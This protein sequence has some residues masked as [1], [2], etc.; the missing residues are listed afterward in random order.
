MVRA[1]F[2][3]ACLGVAVHST[4]AVGA[5]HGTTST[6]A[7]AVFRTDVDGMAA[8]LGAGR[9]TS[10]EAIAD[11]KRIVDAY[12]GFGPLIRRFGPPDYALNREVARKSLFWLSRAGAFYAHDPL[13]VRA[14]L[15]AYDVIGGFYRDNAGF[16][17]P[18][19][20]VAY[21]SAARLAQR[22]TYYPYD[23][24]WFASA[25]DRYALAYGTYAALNGMLI[26][27]WT[28]VQ[29]LPVADVG[30]SQPQ[31]ELTLLALPKVDATGLDAAQR[32]LW[33]EARDRFRA[34][35]SSVHSARVM[36]DQLSERLRQQGLTLNPAIAATALKMQS[37]LEDASELIQA[38]EF[39]TAIE[40][41]RGAEAHRSKLRSVTGQ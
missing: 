21:A 39:E 27:R 18:G 37:A 5:Q 34:A 3:V 35:S 32:Q 28:M 2:V 12:R 24:V 1:L 40:S 17:A 13:A 10:R 8:R 33:M 41:L 19:A 15:D 16:Y 22:L 36:L 6:S 26:P 9:T 29:D 30:P 38:K 7:Q 23:P 25:L 14:F 31:P 11:A 4:A 20:Y